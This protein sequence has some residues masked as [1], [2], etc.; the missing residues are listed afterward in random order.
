[1][2]TIELDEEYTCISTNKEKIALCGKN[3]VSIILSNNEI[4]KVHSLES[5]LVC[6]SNNGLLAACR[7]SV[8]EVY[9]GPSRVWAG[10]KHAKKILDIHWSQAGLLASCSKN[11]ELLVWD[12]RVPNSVMA[13]NPTKGLGV[14]CLAWSRHSNE[15]IASGHERALKLWDTRFQ[16]K[17]LCTIRSAHPER[18]TNLDWQYSGTNLLSSSLSSCIKTWKTTF[19]NITLLNNVQTHSQNINA[20]YSPD[21]NRIVYT[22]EQNEGKINCL[23][24]DFKHLPSFNIGIYIVDMD[25]YNRSL[26]VLCHDRLL[27]IIDFET[28]GSEDRIE[29]IDEDFSEEIFD[30]PDAPC[31]FEDELKKLE[32]N[33]LEGI[34]I[35]D[36][37]YNQRYCSLKIYKNREFLK[38]MVTFPIDYPESPPNFTLHSYSKYLLNKISEEIKTLESKL[39]KKSKIFCKSNNFS[40]QKICDF[41]LTHLNQITDT[42]LDEDFSFIENKLDYHPQYS[43]NASV[44]CIHVWNPS[45]DILIFITSESNNPYNEDDLLEL[46]NSHFQAGIQ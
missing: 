30:C 4:S 17:S 7:E 46:E 12:L 1:M 2:V 22:S 5:H 19:T 33:P 28:E 21:S 35:D 16:K 41:L 27:K 31:T 40:F 13:F 29:N 15:I 14:Y 42:D 23:G 11:S 39:Q 24:E 32:N 45:G 6:Y 20:L 9:D 38:Y 10:D 8:V 37:G 18:L 43:I 25:W 34:S 44:S 26:A 3:G 36:V